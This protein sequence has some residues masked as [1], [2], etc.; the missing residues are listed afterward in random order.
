MA[1]NSK[2]SVAGR[3]KGANGVRL[4]P[5]H[6]DRT[7]AKIQTTQV[8]HRLEDF[9]MGNA[10]MSPAQVTAAL[11]LLRKTL[12][13]ISAMEQKIEGTVAT[14]LTDPIMEEDD[15]TEQYTTDEVGNA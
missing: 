4:D 9:V 12:P 10:E 6:A 15:W 13:D 2:V 14:I 3:A 7:R 11:G 5:K 8:V 1:R